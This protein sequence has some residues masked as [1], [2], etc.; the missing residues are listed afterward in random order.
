MRRQ[1]CVSGPPAGAGIAVGPVLAASEAEAAAIR[2]KAATIY[3]PA[4]SFLLLV[5]PAR[6]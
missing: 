1:Y 4:M 2:P 6:P 3:F 5:T